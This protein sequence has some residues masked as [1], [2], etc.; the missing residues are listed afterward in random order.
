LKPA[1]GVC[2]KV[3]ETAVFAAPVSAVNVSI[4]S[5]KASSFALAVL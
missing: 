2:A 1:F 3:T 4:V 5:V